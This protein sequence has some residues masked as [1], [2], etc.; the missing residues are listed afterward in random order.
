MTTL[1]QKIHERQLDYE[2]CGH[3]TWVIDVD[4]DLAQDLLDANFENNRVAS[5]DQIDRY[6]TDMKNGEWIL[7][8]DA[9]VVSKDLQVGNAQHRL[10][11]V[12]ESGT[13]QRFIVLF[14]SDS[15]AFT[16]FDTGKKRTM[17][18]RITIAGTPISQKEC[19]II[20]HAMNSYTDP[21][22]TGTQEF[23]FPR[24]D[25]RVAK[26]YLMHKQFLRATHAYKPAGSSFIW[27][28]AL[29]MY[30]EM[31]H[32][33]HQY[34]FKHDHDPLTRAQLFIDLCRNGLSESGLS[35]GP[36]ESAAIRLKNMREDRK[37]TN[38]FWCD[39][40]AL[41]LTIVAAHKFMTGDEIKYL[42]RPASDPFRDF[43]F[44]P[45]TNSADYVA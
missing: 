41:Q 26:F 3:Q 2:H 34:M 42:K 16:K 12:I 1:L 33:G 20:R 6:A 9:I 10:Q 13:T 30:A 11:A 27:A 23:A 17:E 22:R 43:N 21:Q 24:H 25:T 36:Q 39:K 38:Q 35:I 4:P 40:T 29:K 7:S 32:Y 19:S 18:Q 44:M 31:I 5:K 15:E 8:N 14:G 45:S 37:K 28:A